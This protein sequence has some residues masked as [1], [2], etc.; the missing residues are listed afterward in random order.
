MSLYTSRLTEG[1]S[2]APQLQPEDMAIAK[3]MGFKTIIC[4]RPDGES[5]PGQP[6]FEEMKKA[7]EAQGLAIHYFPVISGMLTRQDVEQYG[8]LLKTMDEPVLAYCRSG[9]RSAQLWQI[10]QSLMD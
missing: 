1:F 2:V 7:A 10:A 6:T 5:G 4:N 8:E 3:S 9:A